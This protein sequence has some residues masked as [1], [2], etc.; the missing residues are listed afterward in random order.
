MKTLFHSLVA[1]SLCSLPLEARAQIDPIP[2]SHQETTDASTSDDWLALITARTRV[3]E[4]H[5][6]S[7]GPELWSAP[8][9]SQEL[10]SRFGRKGIEVFPRVT[11]SSGEGAAW[12]VQLG[13][14]SFGRVGQVWPVASRAV[15]VQGERAQLDHGP[16]I[17]WFVNDERGIEH[18]WTIATRPPGLEPLVIG[19]AIDGDLSLRLADSGR[20]GV[21]VDGKGERRARYSDLVAWDATG[22]HLR[23]WMRPAPTGVE[24]QVDDAGAVYPVTVDPLVPAR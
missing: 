23:A 2:P 9:R 19:L 20:A 12:R 3:E 17:E 11:D 6:S 18:G 7:L 15:A 21:F 24:V 1:A 8:N 10:R 16:L 14:A 13:T 4:Y 5:F 22:Q